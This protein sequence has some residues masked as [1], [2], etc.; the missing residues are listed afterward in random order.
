MDPKIRSTNKIFHIVVAKKVIRMS[1]VNKN[2][3]E[4]NSDE[5][6]KE[7][8]EICRSQLKA[9]DVGEVCTDTVEA[10]DDAI[11]CCFYLDRDLV[12][13]NLL[14]LLDKHKVVLTKLQ[15]MQLKSKVFKN[16]V[17]DMSAL[18]KS[19]IVQHEKF[20]WKNLEDSLEAKEFH[21]DMKIDEEVFYRR[22]SRKKVILYDTKNEM[23]TKIKTLRRNK[24]LVCIGVENV[25]ENLS[26][27]KKSSFRQ[28]KWIEIT[29]SRLY[30]GV[31]K[32]FP[33][34]PLFTKKNPE[35]ETQGQTLLGKFSTH[36][37]RC[38]DK[39]YEHVSREGPEG[40]TRASRLRSEILGFFKHYRSKVTR[41]KY[42]ILNCID[43]ET[44]FKKLEKEIK[45]LWSL[46]TCNRFSL[47]VRTNMVESFFATRLFYDPKNMKF[48]INYR[49]KMSICGMSWNEKHISEC[50]R[51]KY[52]ETGINY[53]KNW[54]QNIHERVLR[55]NPSHKY[56]ERRGRV[57]GYTPALMNSERE[58]PPQSRRKKRKLKL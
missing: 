20:R 15:A 37:F 38:T 13:S 22:C 3:E 35:G 31:G 45:Q 26:E 32:K 53:R 42:E 46:E 24:N 17:S 19:K 18:L 41:S 51:K 4:K 55:K 7:I 5:K 27:K 21:F 1:Q 57:Q 16:Q 48:P 28:S 8:R 58:R 30:R 52:G 23:N 34:L 36:E 44:E 40:V 43:F 6:R 39:S 50:Y 56:L 14:K 29:D 9:H 12:S 49:A 33:I 25:A 2:N 11:D 10:I 54:H 47:S